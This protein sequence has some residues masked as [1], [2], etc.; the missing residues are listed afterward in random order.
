MQWFISLYDHVTSERGAQIVKKGWEKS[1]ISEIIN[2][3][4]TLPPEDPFAE[5]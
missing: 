3:T 5:L 2:G 1:G 4:V